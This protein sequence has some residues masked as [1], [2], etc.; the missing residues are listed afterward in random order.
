MLSIKFFSITKF[1]KFLSFISKKDSC[2]Q[3][4]HVYTIHA[5][6][7]RLHSF[8][9]VHTHAFMNTHR[10]THYTDAYIHTHMHTYMHIYIYAYFPTY[11]TF[12]TEV[13]NN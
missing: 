9:Y 2:K 1:V 11:I 8:P 3:D 7:L 13:N 5:H 12:L 4:T 10:P 6:K